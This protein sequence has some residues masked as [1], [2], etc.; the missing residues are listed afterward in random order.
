MRDR[1][2][3]EPTAPG[4]PECGCCGAPC[5]VF[6]VWHRKE[7]VWIDYLCPVCE[8]QRGSR[9]DADPPQPDH[10]WLWDGSSWQRYSAGAEPLVASMAAAVPDDDFYDPF[11]AEAWS[12]PRSDLV[13]TG[14]ARCRFVPGRG[15]RWCGNDLEPDLRETRAWHD[16][17]D[18]LTRAEL[19][20]TPDVLLRDTS[21][22]NTSTG[23]DGPLQ[24]RC[25]LN[26]AHED[27]AA[28]LMV[29][30]P[31]SSGVVVLADAFTFEP[32]LGFDS[33]PAM[34]LLDRWISECADPVRLAVASGALG[35][36]S[37]R[38]SVDGLV[39][40]RLLL[41]VALLVDPVQ[42]HSALFMVKS[43][44][45]VT[46]EQ[47]RDRLADEFDD[48]SLR[49]PPYAGEPSDLLDRAGRPIWDVWTDES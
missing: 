33:R 34:A 48:E 30:W 47:L 21:G 22:G 15:P 42:R 8:T 10:V 11:I 14:P 31:S 5:P 16:L 46:A 18:D 9:L 12:A 45:V 26:D 49:L 43:R 35:E 44:E 17:V 19:L 13:G 37:W 25:R 7:E 4:P 32:R 23:A 28:E 3:P 2:D 29:S 41:S 38:R 40:A 6:G 39:R 1:Y 36:A 20:T 24:L 27:R